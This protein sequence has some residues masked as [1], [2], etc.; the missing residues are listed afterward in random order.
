M[1][2][3][4]RPDSYVEINNFYTMTVYNKGAEVIRMMRTLLRSRGLPEG[5]GPLLPAP[6]RT[7]VTTDDFVKAMEDANGAD[8]GQF[9]LW[10]TRQE[11]LSCISPG[12]MTS[13]QDVHGH[14]KTE[15]PSTPGQPVKKP[16]HIPVAVGLL[17]KDGKELILKV[18]AGTTK[19][20]AG[21]RD[22]GTRGR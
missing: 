3:P 9:R 6:R 16:F 7:G 19:T 14:D 2:H 13:R 18:D 5:H 4:V 21:T 15:L 10:Y 22:A 17:G 12:C 1:A 8:L 11:R 20:D